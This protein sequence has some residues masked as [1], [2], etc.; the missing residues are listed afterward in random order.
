[1]GGGRGW[2]GDNVDNVERITLME[3]MVMYQGNANKN[4]AELLNPCLARFHP[5]QKLLNKEKCNIMMK[6]TIH[7]EDLS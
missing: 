2:K 6:L 3:A 1:M 4:K 5:K 7:S